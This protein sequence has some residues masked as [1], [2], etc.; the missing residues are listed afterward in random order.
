MAEIW[1]YA[2]DTAVTKQLL[3][4]GRQLAG[5]G[6][7][8]RALT[9][10]AAA[11]QELVAGGADEVCVLQGNN[12]WP[13]SYA[14][15]VATLAQQEPPQ[16]FLI[17]ATLR[18]KDIAAKIA[19]QLGAGLV[20]DAQS[21]R[22]AEGGVETERMMYGGLAVSTEQVA[23]PALVTIPPRAYDPLAPDNSRQGEII[24]VDAATEDILSV[25]NICP[26]AR[27]G[28]DITTA[29][30][31]VCVGR[32][33]AKQ[34]D[35]KLAEDLAQVLGAEIGCT[36]SVAEDYHW[37]PNERYI[38][39]S[40]QK[41]KPSLYLSL[42][43]SGQIQHVSGMRD[44]KIIVGIDTNENA[45]IFQAADYGIVGDMYEIVPLLTKALQGI[46]K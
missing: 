28:A 37:L 6:Q 19:A 9:L 7:K 16:V 31:L 12:P 33:L 18:G 41:V 17:G 10:D 44:S 36:R 4:L 25:G 43:V 34:E 27:Q 24:T 8:V 35:M 1:T 39:L 15:A 21:V 11:A 45:P 38:G 22:L 5:G 46:A 13:E 29:E 40:G 14:H 32:G 23:V 2:E 42:G 26:I 3:A 20:T 30:K